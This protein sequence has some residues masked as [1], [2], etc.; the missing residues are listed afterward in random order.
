MPVEVVGALGLRKALNQYAPDLAKELT[1][2]LG[3]TLRPIV[4]Q[5]RGFVPAESPMSGWAPRSFSEARFPTY[6]ASVIK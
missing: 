6:N 2:E 1:K 3:A 4:Q 5:A